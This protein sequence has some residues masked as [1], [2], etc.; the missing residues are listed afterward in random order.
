VAAA[1]EGVRCLAP[2]DSS[3]LELQSESCSGSPIFPSLHLHL[4][5]NQDSCLGAPTYSIASDVWVP[6]SILCTSPLQA[7]L[8]ECCPTECAKV[9]VEYGVC[10]PTSLQPLPVRHAYISDSTHLHFCPFATSAGRTWL[11]IILVLLGIP[12]LPPYGI[13]C[14]GPSHKRVTG[15]KLY[16]C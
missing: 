3:K 8:C 16:P 10:F 13:P 15:V 14:C 4:C 2:K 9:L 6:A 12:E 5:Q 7:C 1:E 11:C